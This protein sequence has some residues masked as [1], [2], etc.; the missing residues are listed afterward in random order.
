WQGSQL[1]IGP[2]IQYYLYDFAN[3]QQERFGLGLNIS[4]PFWEER[5]LAQFS[6]S[7]SQ[8]DVDGFRDGTVGLHT[9]RFRFRTSKKSSINLYNAFR[10]VHSISRRS[11]EEWRSRI[12]YGL[13]F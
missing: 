7:I 5:L 3:R 6:S 9:L 2:S 10:H 8:N 4:K 13:R 1:S 11:F 12:G